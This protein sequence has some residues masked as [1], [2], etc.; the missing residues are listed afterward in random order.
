M[1][2]T[3]KKLKALEIYGNA[4]SNPLEIGNFDGMSK[5]IGAVNE[6]LYDVPKSGDNEAEFVKQYPDSKVNN[7]C[8]NNE[9]EEM[10]EKEYI[11][12][13]QGSHLHN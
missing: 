13:E 4:M 5:F 12:Q 8:E 11:R 10:S 9:H 1:E 7:E 3:N 2:N 6:L